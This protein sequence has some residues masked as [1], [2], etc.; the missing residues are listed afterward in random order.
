MNL[1]QVAV[2]KLARNI[3]LL[4]LPLSLLLVFH[5]ASHWLIL[6][7]SF[8]LL[9]TAKTILVVLNEFRLQFAQSVS[10]HLDGLLSVGL[11]IVVRLIV[12]V[13]ALIV[14]QFFPVRHLLLL[15]LPIVSHFELFLELVLLL[16][17]SKGH[18]VVIL[19]QFWFTLL[20]L[21]IAVLLR[22][23]EVAL[24]EFV[25]VLSLIAVLAVVPVLA[26]LLLHLQVV[27]V[28]R[29]LLLHQHLLR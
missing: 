23:E 9:W 8:L 29:E 14:A 12:L 6:V 22:A 21:V 17:L 3:R 16:T 18:L 2:S 4:S 10:V 20:I 26:V 19:T 24:T 5:L 25:S 15:L 13:R 11:V 28:G 7:V 27:L 1:R